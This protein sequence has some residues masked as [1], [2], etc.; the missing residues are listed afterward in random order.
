MGGWVLYFY[1]DLLFGY[2]LQSLIANF[3]FFNYSVN[4]TLYLSEREIENIEGFIEK[5]KEEYTQN[6]DDHSHD[7]IVSNIELY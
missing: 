5:A 6:L 2:P 1:P 3:G 7:L 4:E